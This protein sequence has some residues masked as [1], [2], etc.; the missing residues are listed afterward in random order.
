MAS[1]RK[2]ATKGRRGELRTAV[3]EGGPRPRSPWSARPRDPVLDLHQ[4]VRR[5]DGAEIGTVMGLIFG[6]SHVAL[7]RWDTESTLEAVDDLV[8]V[9]LPR[10]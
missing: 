7:V 3:T 4:P 8:E 2:T 5:A 9:R 6:S 1:K 10:R